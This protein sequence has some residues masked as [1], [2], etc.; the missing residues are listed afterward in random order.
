MTDWDKGGVYYSDIFGGNEG[1]L[2]PDA[3]HTLEKKYLQFFEL[4]RI[5]D[6][7]IYRYPSVCHYV[8]IDI[9]I[10]PFIF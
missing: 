5:D 8:D 10:S 4:F 2:R 3:Q 6:I 1:N 9:N 7:F